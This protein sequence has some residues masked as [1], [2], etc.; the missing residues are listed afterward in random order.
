M[1]NS[2]LI[3]SIPLPIIRHSLC[4]LKGT[5]RSSNISRGDIIAIA[6]EW[7][8]I[9]FEYENMNPDI[10]EEKSIIEK[11]KTLKQQSC[12]SKLFLKL[13]PLYHPLHN[14]NNQK[15]L[16][17]STV[18]Y[19]RINN[20]VSHPIGLVSV[21]DDIG[22]VIVKHPDLLISGTVISE[23]SFCLRRSILSQITG[24]F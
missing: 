4:T 5:W 12:S 9:N 10:C 2:S 18:S 20:P 8:A 21:V 1:N 15:K 14:K 3:N 17:L 13:L 7:K 16:S 19:S 6:T 23:A 22:G 24:V 11:L